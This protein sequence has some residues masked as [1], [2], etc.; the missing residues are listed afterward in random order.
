MSV[1]KII[2]QQINAIDPR[3]I[4]AWG[5][6]D[7]VATS[8]GLKFKTSGMVKWKGYVHVKY[9]EASDLYDIEFYRVRGAKLITDSVLSG[10]YC[11]ML[12]DIIDGQVG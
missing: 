11:D 8:L 2:L 12:V 7:F 5:A 9:N 3:A 6:K 1:A 10:V 4:W